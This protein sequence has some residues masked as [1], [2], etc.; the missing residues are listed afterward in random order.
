MKSVDFIN[1]EGLKSGM[2]VRKTNHAH[3]KSV[4][5]AAVQILEVVVI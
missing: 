5:L 3:L 4:V 2:A 1:L